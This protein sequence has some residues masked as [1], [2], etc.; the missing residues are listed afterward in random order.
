MFMI[1]HLILIPPSRHAPFLKCLPQFICAF[2]C[3][4][5]NLGHNR[6]LIRRGKQ[7]REAG[8]GLAYTDGR[9]VPCLG[10]R[11]DRVTECGNLLAEKS[12][13]ENMACLCEKWNL[14]VSV[15]YN[16]QPSNNGRHI[17]QSQTQERLSNC[18]GNSSSSSSAVTAIS[19]RMAIT[20]RA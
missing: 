12:A 18:N 1:K 11:P 14:S 15:R 7:F 17:I 19:S 9:A 2:D 10:G 20:D 5:I 4:I 8:L 13:C 16:I 3:L 6:R